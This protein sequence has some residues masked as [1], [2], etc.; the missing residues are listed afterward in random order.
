MTATCRAD[1]CS[2]TPRLTV[3][4]LFER[5]FRRRRAAPL[6]IEGAA[7][8]DA[9]G[10]FAR[11]SLAVS[12]GRIGTAGFR[13]SSCA[14]LIALC[15]LIAE[16]V[17]GFTPE[18][19][20]ALTAQELIA[21]LPGVPAYKHDRAVLAVAAFRAALASIPLEQRKPNHEGRLHLR[22]PAA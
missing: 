14:T 15:E 8:T 13:C 2:A 5:G 6:P 12:D 11:F 9:A 4:E 7:C 1:C 19:A 18:I 22:N 21:T 10:N 20:R 17:P 16:T 3:S